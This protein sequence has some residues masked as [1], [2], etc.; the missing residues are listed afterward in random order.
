MYSADGVS[1]KRTKEERRG[2]EQRKRV[3]AEK[4]VLMS[5]RTC[6]G[7]RSSILAVPF[8]SPIT[9]FTSKLSRY[10]APFSPLRCFRQ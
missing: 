10:T 8:S 6:F 5:H 9:T 2:R 7:T 4:R 3:A 1:L